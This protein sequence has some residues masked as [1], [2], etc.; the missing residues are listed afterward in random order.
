MRK[1]CANACLH[2]WWKSERFPKLITRR[3]QEDFAF[4]IRVSAISASVLF[5]A[6]SLL[7]RVEI[8]TFRACGSARLRSRCAT[9]A[10]L[11]RNRQ[12]LQELRSVPW[13]LLAVRLNNARV[14]DYVRLINLTCIATKLLRKLYRSIAGKYLLAYI[15]YP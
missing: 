12:E 14:L 13:C 8:V 11:T 3:N 9:A 10:P 5:Y 4:G 1:R 7:R 2:N 15:C 6:S